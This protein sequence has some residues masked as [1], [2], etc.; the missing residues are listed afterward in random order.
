M[1]STSA[2]GDAANAGAKRPGDSPNASPAG[3]AFPPKTSSPSSSSRQ[4]AVSPLAPLEFLQNQ[5]RGSIT[6]PS[7]HAGPN[8][9]TYH[10]G[11]SSGIT[12]PFRR[13]DSPATSFPSSAPR[14]S[15]RSFS[16]SR[17]LSPYKFGDASSQPNESPSAN[18]RR[19][20]RS[21]SAET[22]RRTPTQ[23]MSMDNGREGSTLGAMERNGSGVGER[24]K[25]SD[26]MDVDNHED[27]HHRGVEAGGN[28]RPDQGSREIEDVDYSGRRQSV[29]AGGTKRKIS[30]D[31]GV[32]SP[33]IPDIDPQLVGQDGGREEEP[34]PKRRGSAIDTQ[35]IAQLSLYDRR[36]SVDARVA[37]TGSPW[38]SNDRRDSTSSASAY[39]SSNTPLTTGYT[40]PSSG[41][42]GPDSPHGR[43]PGDIATFAWPENP[44]APADAAHPT[45]QNEQAVN[46][47]SPPPPFDPLTT[48]MPP[49]TFAPDR[50]MSAPNISPDS[51]P[52][53]PSTGPTR[54]LRSRS[55]PPSRVR[56]ADQSAS[57]GG[58]PG[59][60]T[61]PEDTS[62]SAHASDKA[63][64]STPYSR[65]P[66]LRVSHKLAERKRRKEMKE[67]FDELRDQLPAD[68]GMK[69]SKWEI[70][71][72]AIDFIV[73]LKQSHQ[74]MGRE[75]EMLRHELDGY[76]QGMPPPFAG[77][78]PHAVVYGHGP[79]VGVPPYAPPPG[80]PGA[81][82]QPPPSH[83][84]PHAPHTHSAGPSGPPPTGH[85]G[86]PHHP[87]PLPPHAPPQ[88][89][90][91][92]PG[93]SQNAYP[94]GAGPA[95]GQPPAVNGNPPGIARTETPS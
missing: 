20:L 60:S 63:S 49:V 93:S 76:R 66:E 90:L 3:S 84:P 85:P 61:N 41:I 74:D 11:P 13:P 19:L 86:P 28:A 77:A 57:N 45:M 25:G 80:P 65:S 67:L 43:P 40:T 88:Q 62:T 95:V 52:T 83:Q 82:H 18:L 5:R 91:S 26:H 78:P 51:L 70:L 64:G 12:S 17:P 53:P 50:R 4:A 73:T 71:S 87:H 35:R 47:Q 89:P 68:R 9:P 29:V 6:D 42:P 34:A 59:G 7:L 27:T 14:E 15:R 1:T 92:R 33:G 37:T 94:P 81:P 22:D 56:T 48:I 8:P 44:H 54:A 24:A 39:T 38:W 10:A 30:S 79:P 36:S 32:Y 75:I 21:P 31:K 16:H 55:R 72:K 2:N 58:T 69:A 23:A 46:M